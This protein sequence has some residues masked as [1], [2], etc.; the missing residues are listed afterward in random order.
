M[1]ELQSEGHRFVRLVGCIAEHESLQPAHIQFN[2]S[3]AVLP[4]LQRP[5]H[6][7]FCSRELQRQFQATAAPRPPAR[8]TSYS[9]ILNFPNQYFL[10]LTWNFCKWS[11][12]LKEWA[13][14]SRKKTI[15]ERR[16]EEERKIDKKAKG[17]RK[18]GGEMIKLIRAVSRHLFSHP[19]SPK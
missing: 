1:G 13:M 6:L 14:I 2:S 3:S 19:F 16:E 9:Q 4:D 7:R 12:A 10:T 8:C 18:N 15:K 17:S 11:C 5:H